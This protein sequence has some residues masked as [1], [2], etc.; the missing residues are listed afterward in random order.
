MTIETLS[1]LSQGS[2]EPYIVK[3]TGE[4]GLFFVFGAVVTACLVISF[5]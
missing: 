3:D 5:G 1:A 2:L 4:S